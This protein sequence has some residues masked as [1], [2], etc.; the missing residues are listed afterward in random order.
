MRRRRCIYIRAFLTVCQTLTSRFFHHTRM[1]VY[2]ELVGVIFFFCLFLFIFFLSFNKTPWY[3][4]TICWIF[5][6]IPTWLFCSCASYF[7]A[8]LFFPLSSIHLNTPALISFLLPPLLRSA[9]CPPEH[10]YYYYYLSLPI[11]YI[12]IPDTCLTNDNAMQCMYI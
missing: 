7:L 11:P 8:Y 5:L 6:L 12:F 3:V 2:S 10:H 4:W 9:I 1:L